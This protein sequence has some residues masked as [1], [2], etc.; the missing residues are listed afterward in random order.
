VFSEPERL[1]AVIQHFLEKP[2]VNIPIA[3]AEAGYRPGET[4]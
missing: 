3:T 1:I 4:R 2:T